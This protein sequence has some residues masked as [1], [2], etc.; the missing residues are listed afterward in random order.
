[1]KKILLGLSAAILVAAAGF[2]GFDFYM[3][4]RVK[5]EVEAAFEQIRATG[6]K[7]SHGKVSFD[8]RSRTVTIADIATEFDLGAAAQCQ[9]RQRD[10]IKRQPARSDPVLR[11]QH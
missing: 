8:L 10:G 11:R 2:F 5:G 4:H 3:Q 6:A 7:A 1:M 9:D